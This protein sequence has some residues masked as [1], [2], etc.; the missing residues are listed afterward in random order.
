MKSERSYKKITA[1]ALGLC[2]TISSV[3]VS[4]AASDSLLS[5]TEEAQIRPIQ[6]GSGKYLMKSDG[7]YCL[8]EDGGKDAAAAVHYF[9]EMKIDGTVLDGFYY[10]DE[11]GCYRAES[12]HIVKIS[13]LT[14]TKPDENGDTVEQSFDGYYMVNNLGKLT[15][16]PQVR[17][18]DNLTMD[19]ITFNGY[20]Y[21]DE[22]GRMVTETGMH[23][24]EMS[25]NGQ[26]FSGTYYFGGTNGVLVQEAGTTPDGFPVDENGK[27]QELENLGIENLKPQ[28]ESV[29]AGYDGNWSVYVQDLETGEEIILNDT[30][31]YSASLIKAFVMAKTFEDM[32]LVL[33]N[34]AKQMKTDAENA[35]VQTKVDDLLTNMITVSDNES[36]NELGRLQSEKHDFLDGARKVNEYL[37]KEGYSETSYQSTLH[38][39]ASPK[40]SLGERNMTSVKDCGLLL[41]RIYRGECVSEEASEQMLQLLK[42]QENTTKI[43]AGIRDEV[44]TA[45]KTGETDED[46]HDIAIVYGV[47]TTY[48]LC[49]MSEGWKSGGDAVENIRNISSMVYNYLNL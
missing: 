39:S 23:E 13:N 40:L 38:P 12:P 18:I 22:N 11:S 14:C 10:H 32:E 20:Y 8:K 5:V 33:E 41:E 6:D 3:T 44:E 37:E 45:N 27:V 28:L 49:V 31:M 16:A 19:G 25:S 30:P 21:F 47:K 34:E 35:A 26:M 7:F 29:I 4:T 15:A 48:V 17:Y 9:D 1:L 36:C 42:R 43:P 46:Q 24:L 2:L